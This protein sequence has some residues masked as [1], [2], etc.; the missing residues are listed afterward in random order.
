MKKLK[1]I[2]E[3]IL[4]N[5]KDVFSKFPI[6]MG[7]VLIV[8]VIATICFDGVIIEEDTLSEIVLLGAF[9]AIGTWFSETYFKNKKIFKYISIALSFVIAMFFKEYLVNDYYLFTWNREKT[10]LILGNILGTYIISLS[11]LIIYKLSKD[12]KL[13]IKEYLLNV[14][15]ESFIVGITYLVLNIGISAV[16]A[17][18]IYLILDGDHYEFIIRMLILALGVF[19]IPSMISVFSNTEKIKLNSFIEKLL[20]YVIFPLTMAA[21]LIIY[22]Y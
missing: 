6:T 7:I 17:I 1:L 15:S 19:Y 2:F 5:L 20:L 18:F 3:K 21:I 14:F 8:S 4:N 12:S 16:S 9:W 13:D 10:E 22:L 11:L